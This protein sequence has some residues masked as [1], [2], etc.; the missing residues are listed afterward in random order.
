MFMYC[1]NTELITRK[2]KMSR[3]AQNVADPCQT[4]PKNKY[5][6]FLF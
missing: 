5:L 1:I 4:N 2:L 3:H 6:S